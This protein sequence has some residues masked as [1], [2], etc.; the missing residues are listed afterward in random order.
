MNNYIATINLNENGNDFAQRIG[1]VSIG[2]TQYVCASITESG[3][4]YHDQIFSLE[5]TIDGLP[6][7]NKTLE[8]DVLKGWN[9]H[10]ERIEKA[11]RPEG[12]S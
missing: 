6:A 12:E 11:R 2:L 7:N 5:K 10:L 8:A 9:K 3:E 1:V 4:R